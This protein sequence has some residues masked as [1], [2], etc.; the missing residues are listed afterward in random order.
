M[1]KLYLSVV[2]LASLAFGACSSDDADSKNNGNNIAYTETT[3]AEAPVW[4]VDWTGNQE[5]PEWSEPDDSNYEYWTIL[6]VQIEEALQPFVSDGDMMALFVNG[7]QRGLARPATTIDGD[8]MAP[9]VFLMKA[10]GNG[11][12]TESV[13]I[14]LKYYSQK[15][16]HVFTC[17][18]DINFNSDSS[19]GTDQDYVP[20]FTLGSAKYPV[21]KTV[22]VEPLL[23]KAGITPART[24][25]VG[26]FVGEECRG[27]SMLSASGSTSLVVYGRS[28]DESVI[29]KYYDAST[30]QLFTIADVVKMQ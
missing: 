26:A 11:T 6:M 30:G 7:E 18:A 3:V 23:A 15:L 14:S 1:K 8:L 16:K 12:D 24:G 10:Y 5:R 28:A 21:V 22:I 27:R 2:L 9:A 4:Q 17:S 19:I 13:A 29:L 20:E 25:M